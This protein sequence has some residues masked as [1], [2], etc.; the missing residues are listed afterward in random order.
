MSILELVR[1]H[2][3]VAALR[4]VTLEQ[5]A[6]AAQAL[7]Q[8]GIRL[9][10]VTFEQRGSQRRE[11]TP[12]LIRALRERLSL[13]A[14]VGVGTV[15]TAKEARA[16]VEAGAEFL[17]YPTV[18]E[19]IRQAKAL[20]V[21]VVP[22]ALS[23]T[24]ILRAYGLGADLI[25]LF[26]AGSL[27]LGYLKALQGP[28][29]HIPLLPMGGIGPGNLM[30]Y[31]ALAEGVGVGSQLADPG[32]IRRGDWEGLSRLARTYTAQLRGIEERKD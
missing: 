8:G 26:P 11:K 12:A 30:D 13:D 20:G 4:G 6:D 2:R 19:V 5:A 24:E 21:G 18:E 28:L 9:L 15:L 27:G 10:E 16:A 22:G 25:K 17:L 31:L 7:Y 3:I 1:K 32:L 29:G 14:R 23:P